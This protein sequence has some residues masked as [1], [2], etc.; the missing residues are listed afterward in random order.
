MVHLLFC[1]WNSY[2]WEC[3]CAAR[4]MEWCGTRAANGK[5]TQFVSEDISIECLPPSRKA[6]P[7]WP[8][9]ARYW[10]QTVHSTQGSGER[11][12]QPCACV[13]A[14]LC[15]CVLHHTTPHQSHCMVSAFCTT[16]PKGRRKQCVWCDVV[17]ENL[18][19]WFRSSVL[20][21][22]LTRQ[23]KTVLKRW[24]HLTLL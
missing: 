17:C 9:E 22:S 20:P 21:H 14:C 5:N 18:I 16:T 2:Y 15:M 7:I 11:L 23:E 3:S 12:A 8:A 4:C 1:I 13:C 10:M 19:R 6:V 24:I